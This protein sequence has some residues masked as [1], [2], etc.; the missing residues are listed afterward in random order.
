MYLKSF[1]LINFRKF[2]N[3]FN[4]IEFVD[5]ISKCEGGNLN[6]GEKTTLI[7]GKN[8]A[9]KTTIISALDKLINRNNKFLV[10]DFNIDYL[11]ELIIDYLVNGQNISDRLFFGFNICI[12]IDKNIE[13]DVFTNIMP[14]LTLEEDIK[15]INLIVKIKFKET[16][17]VISVIEK[18]SRNYRNN[19]LIKNNGKLGSRFREFFNEF[20]RIISKHELVVN[21]YDIKNNQIKNFNLSN[22]IEIKCISANNLKEEGALNK[23]FNKI[24]SYKLNEMSETDTINKSI[25]DLNK[26][27]DGFI[28][29]NYAVEL[30]KNV[31]SILTADNVGVSINSNVKIENLLGKMI[32]YSYLDGE[33]LIPEAQFGLG[34]TNIMMII[35]EII[36]Y[37]ERYPNTAFNSKIN[38]LS[39]EEPETFMHP[40]L[41]EHFIKNIEKGIKLLLGDSKNINTQ[42]ILTS[43][44]PHILNSKIHSGNTFNNIVYITSLKSR[45]VITNLNDEKLVTNLKE[46]NIKNLEFIKKHIT[47]KSSTLFFADF[48]IFVEGDTEEQLIPFY[49]QKDEEFLNKLITIINIKGKHIQVYINLIETLKIPCLAICDIDIKREKAEKEKFQQISSLKGRETTNYIIKHYNKKDKDI[50]TIMF[51]NVPNNLILVTQN[52]EINGYYAT[53]LEEA[54]ILTNYKNEILQNCLESVKPNIYKDT[55]CEDIENIK[56]NSYKFQN[57]LSDSKAEFIN[58]VLYEMINSETEDL[59]ILPIYISEGL[60]KL[61]KL[62]NEV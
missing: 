30:K 50:S 62:L 39:I 42:L 17:E 44:S 58:E 15:E 18:C 60:E 48:V 4:E 38:I 24:I 13:N 31:S 52:K 1:K 5:N 21:Y 37:L 49:L 46:E 51:K 35:A 57:K 19:T 36:D 54:F 29:E 7:V 10:S 53:S 16:Q 9:G 34:Y 11:K 28:G 26:M 59:P 20:Y 41:Q 61:K 32:E 56:Q 12:G 25:D 27:I 2:R 8:N 22:L 40:Q 55:V 43:H 45:S 23:A 6:L 47:Y 3:E 33:N 14:L